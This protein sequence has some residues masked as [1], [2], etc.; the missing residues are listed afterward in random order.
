MKRLVVCC[1][2]TWNKPDEEKDGYPVP[3]NVV[4]LAYRIAKRGDDGVPQIVFY[5][6]GVGTGNLFDRIAGGVLGKGLSENIFDVY[7]FLMANYEPGDELFLFGF[8]RGAFT[9]R[10]IAGMIRKCGI[11]RRGAVERYSEA[12]ALYHNGAHPDTAEPTQFRRRYSVVPDGAIPIR[13]IGVWDTVGSL[14]IPMNG[15]VARR[16]EFHDTELSG[17]VERACHALAIDEQRAPFEPTLWEYR[18]KPGQQVEQVW[19]C[20]A[21]SDV[22]GGYPEDDASQI[23]LQWMLERAADAGLQ[24]DEEAVRAYP[25]AYNPFGELHDSRTLLYALR[26]PVERGIGRAKDGKVDS[27]QSV[28]PSV[29]ERWDRDP[30]YRPSNLRRY[31]QQINDARARD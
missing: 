16:Y 25:I 23:P 14:G 3:T 5:E 28:H 29:L 6:L 9:A 20:G 19:F 30:R 2:G 31:L 11:L 22:G 17:T 7:R 26:K 15:G 24:L 18:P 27:T 10:S 1:D 12:K 8:S 21:H 4:K 13:F